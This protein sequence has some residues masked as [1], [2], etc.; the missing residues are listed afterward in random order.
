MKRSTKVGLA[1]TI[2]LHLSLFLFFIPIIP[3]KN[4]PP[5][6]DEIKPLMV[7]L[8]P[9]T[10]AV[11]DE[12]LKGNKDTIVYP[13]NSQ[14][15][16]GKDKSYTGIGLIFMPGSH[17]VIYAPEYYPAY[18]A[19]VRVGDYILDPYSNPINGYVDLEIRRGYNTLKFHIKVDNICYT[20]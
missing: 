14:I 9:K 6:P 10:D 12:V 19:G 5:P 17:M 16:G 20:G 7:R 15:C 2:L 11:H 4:T 3:T 8:L 13:A 1:A 18:K